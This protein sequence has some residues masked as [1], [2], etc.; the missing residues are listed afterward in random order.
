MKVYKRLKSRRNAG[1]GNTE[2]RKIHHPEKSIQTF[3]E[4]DILSSYIEIYL[5]GNNVTYQKMST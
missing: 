2:V 4:V 1:I 5:L 3:F